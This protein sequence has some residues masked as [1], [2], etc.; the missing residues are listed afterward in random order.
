MGGG[1]GWGG[2]RTIAEIG[3]LS[4]HCNPKSAYPKTLRR[5][6]KTWG[7]V[8]GAVE[9]GT[10]VSSKPTGITD[11]GDNNRVRLAHDN[12][13][14]DCQ[15]CHTSWATSRF[16]CHLPIKANQRVPQNKFEGVTDSTLTT[17]N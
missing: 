15:I 1:S 10:A 11:A 8:A 7:A 6:G 9:P 5:D 12:S 16:A 3:P 4:P 17:Y 14:M 2:P 13:A